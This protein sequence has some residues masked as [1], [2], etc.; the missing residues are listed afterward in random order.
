MARLFFFFIALKLV[1]ITRASK[2][3]NGKK[4]HLPR[5][6]PRSQVLS[7]IRS[8]ALRRAGRREPWER[9]CRGFLLNFGGKVWF[10]FVFFF[11]C[12]FFFFKFVANKYVI[13]WRVFPTK[14]HPKG[15][16][17]FQTKFLFPYGIIC[18]LE[19]R[20]SRNN[21]NSY[22]KKESFL[23]SNSQRSGN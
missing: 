12:C 16:V 20:Q 21:N 5:L 10:V 11:C 9:G 7:A 4:V 19:Q 3:V 17:S 1:L 13:N 23:S 22:K 6:Q 8:L 14:T 15:F 2:V 18:H